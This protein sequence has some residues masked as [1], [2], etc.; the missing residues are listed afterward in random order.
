MSWEMLDEGTA[1]MY[2]AANAEDV[3]QCLCADCKVGN[4]DF[5]G[6]DFCPIQVGYGFYGYHPAIK[7]DTEK[8][9]VRCDCWEPTPDDDDDSEPVC[10]GQMQLW[11]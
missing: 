7:Y 9:D 10:D 11:I 2:G 5:K 4:L 6:D 1:R 8:F 3:I